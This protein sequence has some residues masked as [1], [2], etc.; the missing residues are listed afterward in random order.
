MG[1]ARLWWVPDGRDATE[2]AYV[3]YPAD[4]LF[5]IVALESVRAGAFVVG[6]DLGTVEDS[7]RDAMAAHDVLSYRLLWFEPDD[8]SRWPARALAAVTTHDLPTVAG[9]WTGRDLAEQHAAGVAAND[10]AAWALRDRLASAAGL[11]PSVP[12]D[13]TISEDVDATISEDVDATISKDADATISKDVDATVD[14]AIVGAH[15]LLARAPSMLLTVTLDDALGEAARPNIPGT[16]DTR[17]NWSLALP[18][19]IDDIETQTLAT[20]IA[21]T[22]RDATEGA[23]PDDRQP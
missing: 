10:D 3:R 2:G 12:V 6:E 18:I 1:L 20:R 19:P 13:A 21:A 17:P 11:D 7:V 15:R 4:D 16:D 22:L 14:E 9:V 5:A 23:P 8:P